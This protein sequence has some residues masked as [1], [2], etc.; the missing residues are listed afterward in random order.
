MSSHN[1]S[2]RDTAHLSIVGLYP[3]RS[4]HHRLNAFQGHNYTLCAVHMLE[5]CTMHCV[6]S[7]CNHTI[8]LFN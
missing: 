2:S 1:L 8:E 5:F 4:P 7:D 6:K 3:T